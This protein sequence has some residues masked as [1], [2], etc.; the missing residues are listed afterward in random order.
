VGQIF[1][2]LNPEKNKLED[3]PVLELFGEL[4]ASGT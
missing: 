2:L 4:E 1:A 3:F